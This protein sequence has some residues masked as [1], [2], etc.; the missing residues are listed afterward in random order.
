MVKRRRDPALGEEAAL[1]LGAVEVPGLQQPQRDRPLEGEL[2]RL[3]DGA[4]RAAADQPPDPE[5]A[6]DLSLAHR[7][8]DQRTKVSRFS[9]TVKKWKTIRPLLGLTQETSTSLWSSPS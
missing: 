8:R 9:D 1:V 6:D 5:P 7:S 3:V 2:Q 4:A